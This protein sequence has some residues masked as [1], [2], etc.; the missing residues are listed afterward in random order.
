MNNM[1]NSGS[2]G[3]HHSNVSMSGYPPATLRKGFFRSGLR[4]VSR[5]YERAEAQDYRTDAYNRLLFAGCKLVGSDFNM[6]VTTTVDGGPVVEI[7][8]T[9]PNSLVIGSPSAAQGDI[10]A[11]NFND[12]I[13]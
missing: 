13:R 7:T 4:P 10:E 6:P 12:S 8:D 5:S 11:V 2:T 3:N 1:A 9:N